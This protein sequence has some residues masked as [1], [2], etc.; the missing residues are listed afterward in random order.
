MTW[1]INSVVTSGL[2]SVTS[3]LSWPVGILI[4]TLLAL[5][6]LWFIVWYVRS[7]L[8]SWK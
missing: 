2:D 3:L 8:K 7:L 4:W 1:A 5:T 6:I